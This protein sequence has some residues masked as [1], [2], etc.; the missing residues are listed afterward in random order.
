MLAFG[1]LGGT[2]ILFIW[3]RLRYDKVAIL[4]LLA[5]LTAGTVPADRAFSRFSG[6]IVIIGGGALEC[7]W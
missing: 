1:I 2:M 3:G 5:S 7:A 6:D 4:A